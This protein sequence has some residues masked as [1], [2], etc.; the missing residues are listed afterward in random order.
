MET[1]W[2]LNNREIITDLAINTGTTSTP[3]YTPLCVTSE[4][5]I[6]TDM[7]KK[8]FYVFCDAIQRHLVTGINLAL[9][10]TVKV[11]AN[12]TAVMNIF[13]NI[14]T[15]LTSGTISQFNNVLVQFK[16]LTSVTSDALTYTTYQVPCVLEVT[17]LGGP[18]EDE[19]DYQVTFNINGKGTVVTG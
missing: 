11:D 17:D 13:N 5:G 1:N 12:N 9:E 2:W 16:L 3:T 18:A 15:A 8:D 19:A 10:C 4:I 14:N 7:E 6:T